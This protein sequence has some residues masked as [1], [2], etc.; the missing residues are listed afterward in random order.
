MNFAERYGPWAVIAGASE[1]TG[2]SFARQ[3]AAHGVNC[4]LIARR[5]A[6]LNALAEQ[7]RKQNSVECVT[8]SIDLSARDAPQKVAAAVGNREVGLFVMNAGS[9][10]NGAYFLDQ[11]VSTWLELVQRNVNTMM[12]CTHHF[13]GP[14]AQRGRGG[15]LLV[16]SGACYG[17]LSTMGA[18]CGSKAFT[19]CF[20]EGLWGEMRERGVHVLTL[21]M[22][23]TDTPEFRRLMAEKGMPFP[24]DAASPDE[25]AALGLERLPHGPIANWGEADDQ[26]G[27]SALSAAQRRERVIMIDQITKQMFGG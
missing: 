17:G 13:V 15:V 7:I 11:D 18:Y 25:V 19:L 6:P 21:V 16:N 4:V 26:A 22:S 24:E 2:A 20:A 1:G 12:A 27:M 5:E 8:A 14:M 23:K 9:D 3:I 10:P